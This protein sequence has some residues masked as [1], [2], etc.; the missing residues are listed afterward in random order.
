MLFDALPGFLVGCQNYC[1]LTYKARYSFTQFSLAICCYLSYDPLNPHSV[2]FSTNAPVSPVTRSRLISDYVASSC[3]RVFAYSFS[4]SPYPSVSVW[5]RSFD[6]ASLMKHTVITLT[7]FH[8]SCQCFSVA[9][10]V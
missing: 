1:V 3:L 2:C 6:G 7:R 4:S 5:R 8:H 10:S 9:P